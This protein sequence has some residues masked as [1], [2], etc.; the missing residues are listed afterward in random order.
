VET[1]SL[2]RHSAFSNDWGLLYDGHKKDAVVSLVQIW[3]KDDPNA[4]IGLF[5]NARS[6]RLHVPEEGGEVHGATHINEEG[7]GRGAL[8]F[9]EFYLGKCMIQDAAC[10]EIILSDCSCSTSTRICFV[11]PSVGVTLT[12][13]GKE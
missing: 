4:V 13:L 6:S 2:K 11:S 12:A 1:G 7:E 5:E 8:L 10:R 9:L 3:I